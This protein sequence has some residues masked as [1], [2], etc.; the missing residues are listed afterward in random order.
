MIFTAGDTVCSARIIATPSTSRDGKS[1]RAAAMG[2]LWL[3]NAATAS[4]AV[5]AAVTRY[6]CAV[7]M[8]DAMD[9]TDRIEADEQNQLALTIHRS[10]S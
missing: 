4:A 3:A 8:C 5:V 2:T 7:R 6:P 10:R 9:C 1:T